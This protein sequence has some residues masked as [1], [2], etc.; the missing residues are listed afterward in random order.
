MRLPAVFTHVDLAAYFFR[1]QRADYYEYLADIIQATEG[2]RTVKQIFHADA[3]RYG[4]KTIRGALS[5]H[6][7]FRIEEEGDLANTFSGTLPDG[8]VRLIGMLQRMGGEALV[9]GLRDLAALVRLDD[10]IRS[11]FRSTTVMGMIALVIAVTMLVL[12]PTVTVPGLK[13]TFKDI[14]PYLFGS[15][16]ARLFSFSDWLRDYWFLIA[17]ISFVLIL[18]CRWALRNVH[19]SV[20]TWID[21]H[22]PLGIYRDTQAIR[23]LVSIATI[24]KP[25]GNLNIRLRDAIGMLSS[26]ST[27]WLQA[28]LDAIM[29]NLDHS[30]VGARAFNT[31]LLNKSV[32]W[33]LEDLADSLGLGIAL[34]KARDRLETRTLE[35]VRRRAVVLNWILLLGS[36]GFLF[37]VFVWHYAVIF[38]L[39]NLMLLTAM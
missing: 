32:Y 18:G 28:H 23:V 34:Q 21:E 39:R 24:I 14:D 3:D 27:P 30:I 35:A 36:V 8:D 29:D 7:S 19:G 15:L 1:S 12:I 5:A 25:R 2:R 11:I 33:Y 22:S 31:G 13:D 9:E 4:Q 10:R 38:E 17:F 20:R 6:W 26:T 16:A 37:G